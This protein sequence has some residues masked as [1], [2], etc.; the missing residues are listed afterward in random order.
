M[1]TRPG[2]IDPGVILHLFQTLGLTPKKSRPCSTSSPGLLGISGI[3]NDM[4]DLLASDAPE[5]KLAVDFFVYQ[6][7]K[8]IGALAAVLGG[9]A[10]SS[11]LPAFGEHSAPIR[12]RLCEASAWL[13]VALTRRPTGRV[14]RGSRRRTASIGVGDPTNEN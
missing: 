7:A 2:T 12:R 4:R 3:S 14:V 6:A 10:A 1:G 11:S 13:G 8:Q 5:A 9:V